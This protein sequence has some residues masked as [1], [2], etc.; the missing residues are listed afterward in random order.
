[1]AEK[2]QGSASEAITE[3]FLELME[4]KPYM[5]ITVTDI[6]SRAGVARVS[7]YRNFNSTSDILDRLADEAASDFSSHVL[8]VLLSKDERAWQAF[9]FQYLY[10]FG[11]RQQ[12][13]SRCSPQNVS[14]LFS[15]MGDRLQAIEAGGVFASLEDKYGVS[16]R[17]GLL[18][19]V[20]RQWMDEGM[21]E[22]PE[23]MVE[24]L[25]GCMLAF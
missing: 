5:D 2:R 15:R 25:L 20:I 12:R 17:L 8:P 6:V 1:M 14:V 4:E 23:Q 10:Y 22:T 21:Q 7:F 18:N 3:A 16:A 19:N 24:Y 13:L 9:L 11:E